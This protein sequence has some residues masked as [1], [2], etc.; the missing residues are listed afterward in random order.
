MDLSYPYL[1]SYL[2]DRMNDSI[3]EWNR[4]NP[5]QPKAP[6]VRADLDEFEDYDGKTPDSDLI[7]DAAELLA[8]FG[9]ESVTAQGMAALFDKNQGNR[10]TLRFR[11]GYFLRK[12]YEE[13][14]KRVETSIG[15][16]P[17]TTYMVKLEINAID[18]DSIEAIKRYGM[19]FSDVKVIQKDLQRDTRL[20]DID[21]LREEE[22]ELMG[23]FYQKGSL[24]KG[25][26]RKY[27]AVMQIRGGKEWLEKRVVPLLAKVHNLDAGVVQYQKEGTA[28]GIDYRSDFYFAHT[29]STLAG[30]FYTETLSFDNDKRAIPD[31]IKNGTPHIELAFLRGV[32]GGG[33]LS[34]NRGLRFK[35][36]DREYLTGLKQVFADVGVTSHLSDELENVPCG[37]TQTL[38][39]STKSTD[40]LHRLLGSFPRKEMEKKYQKI[41]GKGA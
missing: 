8:E 28:N 5:G 30:R 33:S 20:Q 39:I 2:L 7:V 29:A 18:G 35:N 32:L 14:M 19:K 6:I 23:A 40:A 38:T 31:C 37:V 21:S 24:M 22:A 13:E 34:L 3:H 26:G 17:T 4:E 36:R 25:G 15:T 10:E 11:I 9:K 27:A 12:R 41:V 16:K 1:K